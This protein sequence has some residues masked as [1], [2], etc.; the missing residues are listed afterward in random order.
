MTEEER[1]R[2]QIIALADKKDG[3]HIEICKRYY[4]VYCGI[5]TPVRVE[6]ITRNIKNTANKLH[7]IYEHIKADLEE[8]K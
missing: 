4:E 1:V 7:R 3:I 6:V 8:D 2:N 5:S